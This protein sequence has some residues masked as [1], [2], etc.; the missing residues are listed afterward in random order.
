MKKSVLVTGSGSGIGRDCV[1][2]LGQRGH[3]VYATTH[4]EIQ[5]EQ[6]KGSATAEAF[7]LDITDSSDRARV[8]ELP[9]DVL[10]NN[11]A[12]GETGSLAEVPLERL[13]AAFET[14][15]FATLAITQVVL[16]GMILRR[17]GT[18]VFIS[19]K[20]P[21]KKRVRT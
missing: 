15:L 17:T 20:F 9:I 12:I 7:K 8:G 10:I 2:A 21:A 14:N 19:P 3:K 16:K 11:A 6:L 1:I 4:T 5:A 18:V 13:R